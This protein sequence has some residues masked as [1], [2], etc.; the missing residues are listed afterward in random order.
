MSSPTHG[1]ESAS[2]TLLYESEVVGL[3]GF[4]EALDATTLPDNSKALLMH[5][6][7]GAAGAVI[8]ERKGRNEAEE[9]LDVAVNTDSMTKLLNNTGFNRA[10]EQRIAHSTKTET[11]VALILLDLDYFKGVNDTFGH[12]VGDKVI[13]LKAGVLKKVRTS[14]VSNDGEI[15]IPDELGY[16]SSTYPDDQTTDADAAR[17]GGDEFALL[18]SLDPAKDTGD[19]VEAI[20]NHVREGFL[21]AVLTEL[22]EVAN[23]APEL[24]KPVDVSIGFAVHKPGETADT[25]RERAD[26]HLYEIK[27]AHHEEIGEDSR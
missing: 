14:T 17:L 21:E 24:S 10:L 11:P 6:V 26:K 25:F 1:N 27:N 15:R 18:V 23:V 7:V 4:A 19:Q 3:R 5:I 12:P 8:E 22:P 16:V 2:P 20:I 13:N 9:R